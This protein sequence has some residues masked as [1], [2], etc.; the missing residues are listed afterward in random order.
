MRKWTTLAAVL[1]TAAAT[2]TGLCLAGDD[3]SPMEKI[4]SKVG[5]KH[6]A[7]NKAL[8]TP[9]AFTKAKAEIPGYCDDLIKLG[10]EAREL[11]EAA[12]KQKKPY[13]DWTKLMDDYLKKT[14]EFKQAVS[15]SGVDQPKAKEAY[16]TVSQTCSACHNVFKIEDKEK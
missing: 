1:A 15:K 7:V 10:K 5:G 2:V 14:E 12:E 11:K 16:K 8:R 6:N 3:D 13:E 4:M 9:V